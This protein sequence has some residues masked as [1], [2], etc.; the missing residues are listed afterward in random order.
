M[1]VTPGTPH[2]LRPI[3]FSP[4]QYDQLYRAAAVPNS[5]DGFYAIEDAICQNDQ[6]VRPIGTQAER[7]ILLRSL[8][9]NPTWG[10]RFGEI[11]LEI[12]K[13]FI[14]S[15]PKDGSEDFEFFGLLPADLWA[16]LI[17]EIGKDRDSFDLVERMGVW[18]LVLPVFAD[19]TPEE[20]LAMVRAHNTLEDT[21]FWSDVYQTFTARRW[22]DLVLG[23]TV[24]QLA[25]L[26]F[27]DKNEF[28]P[29][30][31]KR[32]KPQIFNLF[33]EE[34]GWL[35]AAPELI[36]EL[37]RIVWLDPETGL[38]LKLRLIARSINPYEDHLLRVEDFLEAALSVIKSFPLLDALKEL[39]FL[40]ENKSFG[41]RLTLPNQKKINDLFHMMTPC[42]C[43]ALEA[44]FKDYPKHALMDLFETE[45][46]G[47]QEWLN[48]SFKKSGVA[49]DVLQAEVDINAEVAAFVKFMR[50]E[51][52]E[53]DELDSDSDD[54]SSASPSPF[55]SP[56]PYNGVRPPS[57][58]V[59]P[60]AQRRKREDSE[61]A[62]GA[63]SSSKRIR[64]D[65]DGTG[66]PSGDKRRSPWL[67]A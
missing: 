56:H 51:G 45:K 14:L 60:L 19:V 62:G 21:D 7:F 42:L 12:W 53:G 4:D 6:G 35:K 38:S 48:N 32:I 17:V 44:V 49:E 22:R 3:P 58:D 59:T 66:G 37:C 33:D 57:V 1:A 64:R 8:L 13:E 50:D 39:Y 40:K 25:E 5:P 11:P 26:F 16:S 23:L 15:L 43:M 31:I 9:L 67:R 61:P 65:S 24:D 36:K 20:L 54:S 10:S 52:G 41:V 18:E 30:P 46:R 27:Y 63:A 29:S 28:F 55:N 47:V 2:S 34:A